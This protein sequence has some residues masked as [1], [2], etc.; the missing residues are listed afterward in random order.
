MII[1]YEI[2]HPAQGVLIFFIG[3]L[4]KIQPQLNFVY[5]VEVFY[6]LSGVVFI[7]PFPATVPQHHNVDLFA[8]LAMDY[9]HAI[10]FYYEKEKLMTWNMMKSS[11]YYNFLT[12]IDK[13]TE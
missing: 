2:H 11:S 4:W 13:E 7:E 12:L 8:H 6:P 1:Y 9:E 10:N 3:L 5:N